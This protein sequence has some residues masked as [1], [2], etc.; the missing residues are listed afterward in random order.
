MRPRLSS[1]TFF[2]QRRYSWVPAFLTS[3]FLT[4]GGQLGHRVSDVNVS[5]QR[6][7]VDL[8][9]HEGTRLSCILATRSR[10]IAPAGQ[11]PALALNQTN[12]WWELINC[13]VKCILGQL[14]LADS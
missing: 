9:Y 3:R 12:E 14:K 5:D 4:K 13:F 7:S 8:S 1:I 6:R 10:P 11:R 2:N